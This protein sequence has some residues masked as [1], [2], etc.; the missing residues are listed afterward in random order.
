MRSIG[1]HEKMMEKKFF[2]HGRAGGKGGKRPAIKEKN[3]Q[4]PFPAIV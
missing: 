2:F 3:C 4:N 1:K